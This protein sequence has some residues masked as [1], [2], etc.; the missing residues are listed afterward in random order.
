MLWQHTWISKSLSQQC[1]H[2]VPRVLKTGGWKCA[3]H[4][5]SCAAFDCQ[6]S[7]CTLTCQDISLRCGNIERCF[8]GLPLACKWKELV[9]CSPSIYF[10]QVKPSCRQDRRII[11]VVPHHATRRLCVIP[12]KKSLGGMLRWSWYF[13]TYFTHVQTCDV[14]RVQSASEWTSS[15]HTSHMSKPVM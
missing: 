11:K 5:G 8:S 3:R 13:G 12:K 1:L 4:R 2:P 6:A 14:T 10:R 7:H 15:V 9:L